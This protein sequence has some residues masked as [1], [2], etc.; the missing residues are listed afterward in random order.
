MSRSV[1]ALRVAW[2]SIQSLGH[3]E[4]Q[5]QK[6]ASSQPSTDWEETAPLQHF[7]VKIVQEQQA[8]QE[9]AGL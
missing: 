1:F 2:L 7:N 8:I 4:S 5:Q 6:R 9:F 3:T